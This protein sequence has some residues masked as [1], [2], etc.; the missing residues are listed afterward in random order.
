MH[1]QIPIIGNF[2]NDMLYYYHQD[3]YV[4]NQNGIIQAKKNLQED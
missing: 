1:E 2:V 4:V 3:H